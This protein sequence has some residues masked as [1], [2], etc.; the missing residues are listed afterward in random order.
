MRAWLGTPQ[1][2]FPRAC[3]AWV[4]ERM[5]TVL[6]AEVEGLSERLVTAETVEEVLGT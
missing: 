2:I 3:P 4:Q 6:V 5:S 1:V